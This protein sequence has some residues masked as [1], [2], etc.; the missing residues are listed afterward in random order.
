VVRVQQD[1]RP[2]ARARG[3]VSREL[4]QL[5]LID[6]HRSIE[7]H[8]HKNSVDAADPPLCLRDEVISHRHFQ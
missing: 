3:R 1:V 7:L 4:R 5:R 6:E 2:P 8:G